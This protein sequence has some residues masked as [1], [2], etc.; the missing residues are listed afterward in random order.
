MINFVGIMATSNRWTKSEI[1]L[2]VDCMNT[3]PGNYTYGAKIASKKISRS[4]NAILLKFREIR[5]DYKTPIC[6]SPKGYT[7]PN[8]QY[9]WAGNP[10]VFHTVRRWN[11]IKHLIFS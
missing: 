11:N 9:R 4:V 5:E 10:P 2:V 8:R 7:T 3:Y 1:E 6:V